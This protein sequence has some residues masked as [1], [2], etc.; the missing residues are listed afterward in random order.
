MS[1]RGVVII[2]GILEFETSY[3]S[4]INGFIPLSLH[5]LLSF[6]SFI[7]HYS[8]HTRSAHSLP[9]SFSPPFLI[10]PT[11]PSF[12]TPSLTHSL[13]SYQNQ[14]YRFKPPSLRT[15]IACIVPILIRYSGRPYLCHLGFCTSH[16][17]P[18]SCL[19]A[20]NADGGSKGSDTHMWV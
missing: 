16:H 12:L 14:T 20:L 13:P 9:A 18:I 3:W 17:I 2:T 8:L 15:L 4:V 10:R 19:I 11:L 7:R 5:L 1:E 6:H